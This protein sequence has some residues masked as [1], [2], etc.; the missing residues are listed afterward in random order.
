MGVYGQTKGN[1]AGNELAR[2]VLLSAALSA[3]LLLLT[4]VNAFAQQAAP[5]AASTGNLKQILLFTG[6][7]LVGVSIT[8]FAV[9]MD[10]LRKDRIAWEQQRHQW[11]KWERTQHEAAH[12]ASATAAYTTAAEEKTPPSPARRA[13]TILTRTETVGPR[14]TETTPNP[15]GSVTVPPTSGFGAALTIVSGPDAGRRFLMT[16]PVLTIGREDRDILLTD[17]SISRRHAVVRMQTDAGNPD[18]LPHFVLYDENSLHGTL[19]NDE[20]LDANGRELQDGDRIT[21]GKGRT[22]FVFERVQE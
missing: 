7:T 16:R 18:K 20:R 5:A 12:A 10:R 8:I 19:L 4:T 2:F 3:S 13:E 14:E 21:L 6:I 17:E 15:P 1:S 22:I 9:S 11:E